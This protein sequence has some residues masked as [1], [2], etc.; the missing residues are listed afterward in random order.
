MMT[1]DNEKS[2]YSKHIEEGWEIKDRIF[3]G[4]KNMNFSE[5]LAFMRKSISKTKNQL[6][7]HYK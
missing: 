7:L 4:T 1:K 2:G 5:Y 6:K 3:K